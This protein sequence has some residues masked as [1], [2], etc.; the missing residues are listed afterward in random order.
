MP[1]CQKPQCAVFTAPDGTQ[2][3][4][5]L[6]DRRCETQI[7]SDAV[8]VAVP[9]ATLS[10]RFDRLTPANVKGLVASI[11]PSI[12]RLG[13]IFV[14]TTLG[15]S[16]TRYKTLPAESNY[17]FQL[18]EMFFNAN[19]D[20]IEKTTLNCIEECIAC[21]SAA[22]EVQAFGDVLADTG[23][24]AANHEGNICNVSLSSE[25]GATVNF[26]S[27]GA[28]TPVNSNLNTAVTLRGW[29]TDGQC[30]PVETVLTSPAPEIACDPSRPAIANAPVTDASSA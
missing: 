14:A 6:K 8:G 18:V 20:P 16:T 21:D 19:R 1:L 30:G 13:Q 5:P 3:Q 7:S 24:P 26:T 12:C 22:G 28:Y 10:V 25:D 23:E 27:G 29:E 11:V 4:Q 15:S 2:Y 9:A 17:L